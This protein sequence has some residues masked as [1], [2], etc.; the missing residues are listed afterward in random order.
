MKKIKDNSFFIHKT[1][2]SAMFVL[3]QL[4]I[5]MPYNNNRYIAF[6]FCIAVALGTAVCLLSNMV[7]QKCLEHRRNVFSLAFFGTV[8]VFS[9][10]A[11]ADVFKTYCSFANR[12]LLPDSKVIIVILF[13]IVCLYFALKKQQSQLKFGLLSFIFCTVAIIL[14]TVF[15]SPEF[16]LK[17]MEIP[18]DFKVTELFYSASE[19]FFDFSLPLMA[20]GVYL[21]FAGKNNKAPTALGIAIGGLLLGV[22]ILSSVLLFGLPFAAKLPFPYLE[23]VSCVAI[24][25]LFSRMDLFLYTVYMLTSLVKTV[26]L[27]FCAVSCVKTMAKTNKI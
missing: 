21:A 4:I 8:A 3:G 9:A 15:L 1:A 20:L 11:A 18:T 6:S 26:V 24:G 7:A 22:C 27:I 17:N 12:V 13:G 14:F 2:I 16:H 23:A 19:Y 5:I 25:R 10:F